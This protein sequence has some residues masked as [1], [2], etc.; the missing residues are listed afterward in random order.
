[1]N[2]TPNGA[3]PL[4]VPIAPA[5]SAGTVMRTDSVSELSLSPLRSGRIASVAVASSFSEI[6]SAETDGISATA[7]TTTVCVKA[8]VVALASLSVVVIE[9][10]SVKFVSLLA[11]AVTFSVSSAVRIAVS[12]AAECGPVSVIV[13]AP[14]DV[15][16]CT[17]PR[18]SV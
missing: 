10:F 2:V 6:A 3:V 5:P 13:S 12:V 17:T 8:C 14:V 9:T 11:G 4:S 15:N 7:C 18:R 1:M 16:D